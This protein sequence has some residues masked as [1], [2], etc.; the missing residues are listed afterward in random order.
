MSWKIEAILPALLSILPTQRLIVYLAEEAFI[1]LVVTA[2]MLIA[3]LLFAIACVLF[4]ELARFVFPWL[5]VRVVWIGSFGHNH[6][7]HRGAVAHTSP[8][9]G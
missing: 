1:V 7:A 5:K 2:A 3:T 9:R 8:R 4:S 6:I